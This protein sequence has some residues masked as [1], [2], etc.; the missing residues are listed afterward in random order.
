MQAY[1]KSLG[2]IVLISLAGEFIYRHIE[3]TNLVM[4][5]LLAV[6][7]T[8]T[9]WGKG[10]AIFTS[11]ISVLAFD[12]LFV[13]P[14]FTLNVSDAQY[15]LTFMG[16]FSVGIVI[17]ELTAKMRQRAVEAS[18]RQAQLELLKAKEKLQ[19]AILNSISHDLRTPLASITGA[20]SSILNNGKLLNREA[21]NEL[22]ETAYGESARLNRL[23][24]NILDMTKIE[25]Q[26][27]R[28]SYQACEVRD[29]IAVVLEQFKQDLESRDVR[30]DVPKDLPDVAIDF[31]LITKVLANVIDNAL[32]Y[33]QGNTTIHISAQTV[34]DSLY[35]IISDEG[36]GIPK[37]DLTNVFNKFYRVERTQKSQGIGLGLSI[38]K[39][40]IE[41]HKGKILLDSVE[42]KGTTI[43]I[44][45]PL[46]Q[47]KY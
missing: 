9:V 46:K 41:A 3:P 34:S 23:V 32:K 2:L 8:A 7:I 20:L 18:R 6:V 39:G 37:K 26:A 25:A 22:I 44:E 12:F 42:N 33:S 14:R 5:Y 30:I 40:I 47:E 28:L 10:P 35:I 31:T 15:L 29:V 21:E 4:L 16:L 13:P 19:A 24:E 27:L 38:C 45:L 36:F 43:S 11:I 1:L 17:S